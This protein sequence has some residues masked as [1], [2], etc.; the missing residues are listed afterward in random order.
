MGKTKIAGQIF[1]ELPIAPTESPAAAP[2]VKTAVKNECIENWIKHEFPEKLAQVLPRHLTPT[3]IVRVVLMAMLKQPKLRECTKA[4][5]LQCVLTCSSLGL[6]PD[7][8]RAH[9]IPFNVNKKVGNEWIH[10]RTD[11]T[12]I[13][14]YKGIVEL[15]RRSGEVS[16]I[17]AD[18]VREGDFFE[19]TFGTGGHLVHKPAIQRGKVLTAYSYV[20]LRDGSESYDVMSVDELTAIRARSKAKNSGPWVTDE[21]EMQKK[22]VFRRH[23]K[24]LP[25]S[26]EIREAIEADDENVDVAGYL[27]HPKAGVMMPKEIIADA[28]TTDACESGPAE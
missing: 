9:L 3:R 1:G 5:L 24:W 26:A 2:I 14:D 4:S 12:L 21:A 18:V 10:D 13:I 20:K 28:V 23:S 19:Y 25:L 6:E 27:P 11:C 22:T 8:R 16:D 7:G 15:V 17:H